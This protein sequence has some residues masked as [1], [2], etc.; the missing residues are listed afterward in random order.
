M[1]DYMTEISIEEA[2]KAGHTDTICWDCA[3]ACGGGCSWADPS[4]QKPVKGWT[5]TKTSNGYCVHACPEFI[6]ET[7]ACGRYRTADDYIL[8]LEIALT[9]RKTQ[10]ARAKRVPGLLRK[11]NA[12]L[13]KALEKEQ[14]QLQVHMSE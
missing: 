14:W 13:K 4:K 3:N 1:K 6:R 11:K 5:A 8:A 12:N 10:L 9:E 2:I 7:Y